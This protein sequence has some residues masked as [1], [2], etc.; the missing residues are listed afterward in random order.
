MQERVTITHT[1]A[2][3]WY[4]PK[5]FELRTTEATYNSFDGPDTSV[6]GFE[7]VHHRVDNGVRTTG[8]KNFVT[9]AD[10]SAWLKAQ[11]AFV[12]MSEL[13]EPVTVTRSS[14]LDRLNGLTFRSVTHD[15]HKVTLLFDASRSLQI[16]GT[17]SVHTGLETA[18]PTR[19]EAAT[20]IVSLLGQ[21]VSEADELGDY[22]LWIPFQDGS[23]LS[24]MRGT[25]DG[26]DEVASLHGQKRPV[27][28]RAWHPLFN[29]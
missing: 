5:K 26:E 7:V 15:Q 28:W 13:S 10:R 21:R 4:G 24:I 11:L 19:S 9:E 3:A 22:G 1:G 27:V 6:S 23:A 20:D 14:K 17:L 25:C 16:R 18:Q 8:T 29:L 2:G 12:E